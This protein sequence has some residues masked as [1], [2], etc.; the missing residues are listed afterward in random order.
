M[1]RLSPRYRLQVPHGLAV[2]GA[3]LLLASTLGGIGSAVYP[4]TPEDAPATAGLVS[5]GEHGASQPAADA[6]SVIPQP[7]VKQKKHFRIKLFLFRR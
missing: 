7:A 5:D 2:I 4:G 3:L 1:L 6:A